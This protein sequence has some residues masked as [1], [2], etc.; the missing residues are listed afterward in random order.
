MFSS[1]FH[2]GKGRVVLKDFITVHMRIRDK[3]VGAPN[4]AR[5]IKTAIGTLTSNYSYDISGHTNISKSIFET[6]LAKSHEHV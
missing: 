1:L 2:D 5:C 3:R 6:N 4:T